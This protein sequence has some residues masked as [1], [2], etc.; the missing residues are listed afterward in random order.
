MTD[1]KILHVDMDSFYASVEKQRKGLEGPIVICVYSGRTEDSGA[2]STCNYEARDMGIHAAMPITR[3]KN[4][5]EKSEKEV[6]FLPMDREYYQQISDEIREQIYEK[7]AEK[8]EQASIDEAYLDTTDKV[9]S[10]D[11]AEQLAE[12]IQE[13]VEEEFGITCSIGIG[14]NKLVAKIA[15]DREKPE[16]LTMVL[17]EEVQE[18]MQSLELEDIHGIGGKTVEK[19]EALGIASVKELAEADTRE[20]IEEFGENLGVKIQEKACGQDDEEVSEKMQKQITRITTLDQNSRSVN[21]IKTYFPDLAD[22]IFEQLED[23]G[24]NF[25]QV[26]LVV[27]D[28]EIQMHTRSKTLK[29]RIRDREK[30]IEEEEAL[31]EDFMNDF[32]GE[33]RRIGLRVSDLEEDRGQRK[34]ESF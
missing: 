9:E 13:E 18:F 25:G 29:A 1:R 8:I 11:E 16:G 30:F 21:H 15:S 24:L 17:P 12:K 2:V 23:K 19:L 22:E 32:D 26:V 6:H 14:P 5:A 3:A 31:L 33:V 34:L 7:Y 20:L 27:I 28:S 4:I 10:F